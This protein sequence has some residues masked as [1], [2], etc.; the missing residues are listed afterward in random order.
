MT[1]T[2]S[3]RFEIPEDDW[4]SKFFLLADEKCKK[5]VHLNRAYLPN[6]FYCEESD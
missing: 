1:R 3:F 6:L 2:A 4:V 5:N